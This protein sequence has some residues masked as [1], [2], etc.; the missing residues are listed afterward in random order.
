MGGASAAPPPTPHPFCLRRPDSL[1]NGARRSRHLIRFLSEVS[2]PRA[3]IN[4]QGTPAFQ[5]RPSHGGVGGRGQSGVPMAVR[6]GSKTLTLLDTF[7]R[8]ARKLRGRGFGPMAFA[9]CVVV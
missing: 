7:R 3:I 1:I 2:G 5:P 4:R 6:D 9:T 8:M